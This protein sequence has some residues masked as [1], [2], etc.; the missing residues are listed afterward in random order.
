MKK[1]IALLFALFILTQTTQAATP[2]LS[3]KQLMHLFINTPA[4]DFKAE[5]IKQGFTFDKQTPVPT[6]QQGVKGNI[7]NAY[8]LYFKK[9]TTTLM[10]QVLNTDKTNMIYHLDNAA[11]LNPLKA[12]VKKLK[13]ELKHDYG[14]EILYQ[15]KKN[16]GIW[17]IPPTNTVELRN[18]VYYMDIQIL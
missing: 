17:F 15:I 9:G 3:V 16:F 1:L 14:T 18:V 11:Q 12:Q 5:A 6:Y 8:R 4:K 2:T 10:L 13:L 7:K